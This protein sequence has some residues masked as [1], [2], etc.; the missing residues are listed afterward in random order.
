VRASG[1]ESVDVVVGEEQLATEK[2]GVT[3]AKNAIQSK[4]FKGIKLI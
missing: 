3:D 1:Q 2:I 4:I